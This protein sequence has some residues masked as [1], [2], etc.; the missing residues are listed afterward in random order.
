MHLCNT[1]YRTTE[2]SFRQSFNLSI[3]GLDA[4]RQGGY[5]FAKL[6]LGTKV[7]SQL[8]RYEHNRPVLEERGAKRVETMFPPVRGKSTYT[9]CRMCS[10]C[11]QYVWGSDDGV[12][13]PGL[14]RPAPSGHAKG[15][16]TFNDKKHKSKFRF[17][18]AHH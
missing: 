18:V 11:L 12:H 7:H 13:A 14:G 9:C 1:P 17:N 8:H 3:H 2:C 4:V 6:S 10:M 16:M 5:P 15:W